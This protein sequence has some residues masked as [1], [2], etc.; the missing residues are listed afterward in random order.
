MSAK[1]VLLVSGSRELPLGSLRKIRTKLAD[2]MEVMQPDLVVQGGAR[3]VD[4]IVKDLCL[5]MGF[6][7]ATM[8]AA[9]GFHGKR[10]GAIRNRW[11]LDL[12]PVKQVLAFPIRAGKGTQMTMEMADELG[13]PVEV[14]WIG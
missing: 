14:C 10:A 12:F 2:I 5:D 7:C 6:P 4:R 8:E 3:G 9:W 11:M 1:R 13:I